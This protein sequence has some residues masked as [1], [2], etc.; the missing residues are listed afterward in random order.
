M[1]AVVQAA[2]AAREARPIHRLS[3]EHRPMFSKDWT[4]FPARRVIRSR[5]RIAS[6]RGS[7]RSPDLGDDPE[8]IA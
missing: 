2:L 4:C 5:T 6:S 1:N 3:G 7:D 8:A